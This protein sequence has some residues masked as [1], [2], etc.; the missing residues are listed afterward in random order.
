MSALSSCPE[1]QL[2]LQ[3]YVKPTFVQ[4]TAPGQLLGSIGKGRYGGKVVERRRRSKPATPLLFFETLEQ[5]SDKR[6]DNA[7]VEWFNGRLRD[8]CLNIHW[9]LSLDDARSKI[10]AWRRDY[11]EYR[12]HTSLG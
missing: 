9:F 11:I 6:T 4:P 8:E 3:N 10:E 7:F 2:P 1:G 12:P 5:S